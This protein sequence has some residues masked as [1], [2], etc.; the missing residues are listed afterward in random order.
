M[1]L[2]AVKHKHNPYNE[3][4]HKNVEKAEE[5]LARNIRKQAQLKEKIT[6]LDRLTEDEGQKSDDEIEGAMKDVSNETSSPALA[7]MLGGMWSEMREFDIPMY[8]EHLEEEQK[9]LKVEEGKLT[10]KLEHAE[11]RLKEEA[12]HDSGKE[13]DSNEDPTDDHAEALNDHVANAHEEAPPCST[14]KVDF[15]AMSEKKKESFLAGSCVYLLGGLLVAFLHY[16]VRSWKTLRV[17]PVVDVIRSGTDFSFD[18]LGCFSTPTICM[19]GCLCPCLQWADTIDRRSISSAGFLGYWK[20]F[21]SFFILTVLYG[22]TRG[23]APVLVVLLGV[24]YRQKLRK[25]Y[26]IENGTAGTVARDCLA[27]CCCQPCAII[28]E[29][30][31]SSILEQN[32]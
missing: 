28:Q 32:P 6:E 24:Y 16:K 31:E 26:N 7:S 13:G 18:L 29:A 12:D 15:W 9:R 1:A 25:S 17:E 14:C 4:L 11:G 3:K 23:V 2:P 30:R 20:A 21:L 27:W 8:M 22:F 10:A 19:V 5:E